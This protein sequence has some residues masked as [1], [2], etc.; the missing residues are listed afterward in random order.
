MNNTLQKF[1]RDE[2]KKGLAKCTESQQLLFKRMY[3]NG[4]LEMPID[5][6]VDNMPEGKLDWAMQQVERANQIA[7]EGIHQDC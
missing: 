2:L 6:I 1:A 4:N 3:A 7:K 5:E